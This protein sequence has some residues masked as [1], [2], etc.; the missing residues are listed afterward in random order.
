MRIVFFPITTIIPSSCSSFKASSKCSRVMSCAKE[1]ERGKISDN[2]NLN[3]LCSTILGIFFTIDGTIS[4]KFKL[5][6]L[7]AHVFIQALCTCAKNNSISSIYLC[8]EL[9][10]S[11]NHPL[12]LLCLSLILQVL[13][14]SSSPVFH[15]HTG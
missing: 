7:H 12:V 3:Q 9:I 5:P 13:F 8:N 4:L 10:F 6:I 11:Q 14:I 15:G 2:C 1:R